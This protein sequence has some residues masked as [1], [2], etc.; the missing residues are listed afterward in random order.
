MIPD[1]RPEEIET[2]WQSAWDKNKTF[3]T[4]QKPGQEK[5]YCLEMLPYPSG[6][7]HM[8]HVRNYSLGDVTARFHRMKGYNVLHPMGWDAFGLPAENAAMKGKKSPALWTRENI[9]AMKQQLKRMGFSYDWDRE[10]TTC[11]PDY[12]RWEQLIFIRMFEKGLIY[13]KEKNLNWCEGC[14]TVLANEQVEQGLC[15]RCDTPVIQKLT[16]QWF[17]KITDYAEELL[18]D[19]DTELQGWPERVRSMQRDW[20]GRSEGTTM[21]FKIDG[22]ED[23]IAIF[24]TRPDTLFGVT[25]LSLAVDHPLVEKLAKHGKQNVKPFLEETAR[26][27]R[28]ERLLGNFEKRGVAT[29]SYVLHPLTGEKVPVYI[30]NFVL[31]DYGTG[32][33]MAVPAHDQRD[34]DFAK[35]YKLPIKL[36]IQPADQPLESESLTQAYEGEGRLVDSGVFSG[37]TSAEARRKITESLVRQGKG[38]ASIHYRLKDWCVSR[39]RYWGSPIPMIHCQGCGIVPVA[40]KD[41]PIRLPEE[42]PLTGKGGSPLSQVPAFVKATCPKCGKVARRETDTMDTFVESSWYLLRYASPHYEKG[43]VDPKEIEAW[44]PVDQYIGGIEHAVGHLLYCRFFTKVMRDLG[45]LN[46]REPVKNLLTQGM[47][48]LGGS[49]MSKSKGNVVDPD[50]MIAKYGA[51]TARLFVLFAAPP[52]KDLDWNEQGV[53][54][55]FRFLKKVWN[56]S[57]S[58]TALGEGSEKEIQWRHK[59]IKRVTDDFERFHFNTAVSGLMEFYNFLSALGT[60][61]S[62]ASI[63]TLVLLLSPMAPHIA[64]E[65]WHRLG[66]KESILFASWPSHDKQFLQSDEVLIVVQVNGKKRGELMA[67]V[68]STQD[69]VLEL[70]KTDEKITKHLEGAAIRKTIYVPGRLINLVI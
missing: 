65:L 34:F 3:Q 17:V 70:L 23:S 51:D 58:P 63:E 60:A 53:A 5:Y 46:L 38:T 28:S 41:L 30:T 64:E 4:V 33:V 39:Q 69:N 26:L 31:M 18:N 54:G 66:H 57:L 37:L 15:W 55:L 50:E 14:Q 22:L 9:A 48:C 20:I 10:V 49:A 45:F 67:P 47:V 35:K 43:P 61:P 36:V 56:F 62:L 8:G 7:C 44:L 25:F 52:E 11:L 42:A 21:Q 12:Y 13:R 6:R 19:I 32:A 59:T 27:D 24:T 68:A 29:G 1:Y 40:E 2:R 16:E